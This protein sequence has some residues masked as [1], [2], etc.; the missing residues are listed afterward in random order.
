MKLKTKLAFLFSALILCVLTAFLGLRCQRR[1]VTRIA[2]VG[3]SITYGA[4]ISH[5]TKNSYPARLQSLL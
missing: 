3:D 1:Q 5:I 2:C 4:G